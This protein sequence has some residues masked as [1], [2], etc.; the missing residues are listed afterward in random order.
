MSHLAQVSAAIMLLLVAVRPAAGQVQMGG[1]GTLTLGGVTYDFEVQI[2]G[3]QMP[4]AYM[5][6]GTGE[7]ANGQMFVVM[8]M[9]NELKEGRVEET[10]TLN[11]PQA[12]GAAYFNAGEGW[13]RCTDHTLTCK[14]GEGIPV[15]GRLLEFDG[16]NVKATG[17][18]VGPTTD[19]EGQFGTLTATCGEASNAESPDNSN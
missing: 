8:V 5:L 17:L 4:G 12:N 16:P 15:E 2:C 13:K 18:F 1:Q 9:R 11:N 10:V 19:E 7:T 6:N 14:P 3:E